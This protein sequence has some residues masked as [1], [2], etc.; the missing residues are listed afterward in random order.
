MAIAFIVAGVVVG[1]VGLAVRW[2]LGVLDDPNFHE[3]NMQ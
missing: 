2:S 3:G 1:A